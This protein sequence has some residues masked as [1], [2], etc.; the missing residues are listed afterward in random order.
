MGEIKKNRA[1]ELVSR[2]RERERERERE[3]DRERSELS[4]DAI[5]CRAC[6]ASVFGE[7]KMIMEYWWNETDRGNLKF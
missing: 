4:D 6:I 5:S 2:A 1:A 7:R 3:R